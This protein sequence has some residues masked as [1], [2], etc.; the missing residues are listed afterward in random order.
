MMRAQSLVSNAV[1][2]LIGQV[3]ALDVICCFIH[4]VPGRGY[5][6]GEEMLIASRLARDSRL[7]N[8]PDSYLALSTL[9]ILY[10]ACAAN[11]HE[12]T[13]AEL[14]ELF[15]SYGEREFGRKI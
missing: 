12:I 7:V 3:L 4:L 1:S 14:A 2:D 10:A 13:E 5:S 11:D 9:A 15:A 8:H 6:L